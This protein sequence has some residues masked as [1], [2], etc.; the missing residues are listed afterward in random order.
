MIRELFI[1]LVLA[2]HNRGGDSVVERRATAECPAG[3]G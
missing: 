1:A 3:T 2:D